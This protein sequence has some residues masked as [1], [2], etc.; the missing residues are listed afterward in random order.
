MNIVMHTITWNESF[1]LPYTLRHYRQF[2]SRIIVHDVGSTDG[3]VEIAKQ[4][5]AEVVHHNG[6]GEFNDTLNERIKFDEWRKTPADWIFTID[7]D[8]IFYFP[9]GIEQTLHSYE[10]QRLPVVRPVGYEMLSDFLP[11]KNGQIYDECKYGAKHPDYCKP[12]LFNPRMVQVMQLSTGG[13]TCQGILKDGGHFTNPSTPSAPITM[14]LHYHQIGPTEQIGRKYEGV[15][16]RLSYINKQ[17]GWGIQHDGMQHA[18][19]K[20]AY[21]QARLERVIP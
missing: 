13:H 14:L 6:G 17:N 12:E 1:I 10:Q 20:R 21:I 19:D 9:G 11:S 15:I 8:E 7:A 5:G 2:C 3:T 4:L 18:R 16:G